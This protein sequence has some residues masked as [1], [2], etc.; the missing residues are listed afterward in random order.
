MMRE[1][2]GPAAKIEA[3]EPERRFELPTD[4][5]T[6]RILYELSREDTIVG[7]VASVIWE[8]MR[9]HIPAWEKEGAPQAFVL[10][11]AMA[12]KIKEREWHA[13]E[14]EMENERILG[15]EET[16]RV[17]EFMESRDQLDR[18]LRKFRER[19]LWEYVKTSEELMTPEEKESSALFK[20]LNV[21]VQK[22][23]EQFGFK[24]EVVLEI[25][26]SQDFNAFVFSVAKE[27]GVDNPDVPLRIYLHAGLV[28]ALH[29]MMRERGNDLAVDHV[30]GILAHEL[31]HLK[32]PA[33]H[34]DADVHSRDKDET[35]RYEYDAD[36]RAI[37]VM[38]RS[39][40]NPTAVIEVFEMMQKRG[41]GGEA[42]LQHYL[43]NT[44]PLDENRVKELRQV[45]ENPSE[46]FFSAQKE[47]TPLSKEAHE[48]VKKMLRKDLLQS[49]EHIKMLAAWDGVL[50]KLEEDPNMN[51]H[52]T[53]IVGRMLRVH[54]DVRTAIAG[55]SE[56][57]E[58]DEGISEAIVLMANF[59]IQE[60][61]K[62]LEGKKGA[63]GFFNEYGWGGDSWSFLL[64]KQAPY[65]MAAIG[66]SIFERE[67]STD[68]RR[69]FDERQRQPEEEQELLKFVYGHAF[70]NTVVEKKYI[71][72]M[73]DLFNPMNHHAVNFWH[74]RIGWR[75]SDMDPMTLM[76]MAR[77]E[78]IK[79]ISFLFTYGAR[80]DVKYQTAKEI[81]EK[82]EF[83]RVF[84]EE[85]EKEEERQKIP[86]ERAEASSTEVSHAF[87]DLKA[88]GQIKAKLAERLSGYKEESKTE[89][90]VWQQSRDYHMDV[91]LQK[92]PARVSLELVFSEEPLPED[93]TPLQKV[94]ARYLRAAWKIFERSLESEKL[95]KELGLTVKDDSEAKRILFEVLYYDFFF[96]TPEKT[97]R[98]SNLSLEE[99]KRHAPAF[100]QYLQA[101]YPVAQWIQGADGTKQGQSLAKYLPTAHRQ[102]EFDLIVNFTV[103]DR[104]GV[105]DFETLGQHLEWIR[106]IKYHPG[107]KG[108]HDGSNHDLPTSWGLSYEHR[109]EGLFK[110]K[111]RLFERMLRMGAVV[112][113]DTDLES[114]AWEVGH[115]MEQAL[116]T[117]ATE[118]GLPPRYFVTGGKKENWMEWLQ[119]DVKDTYQRK[120]EISQLQQIFSE[121][122]MRL[123]ADDIEEMKECKPDMIELERAIQIKDFEE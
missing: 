90:P 99:I 24:R 2:R 76:E 65:E 74:Q 58:R 97:K 84:F 123:F 83:L 13:L 68:L 117:R 118:K 30:M 15:G 105:N 89:V 39:G 63:N 72:N 109:R 82:E 8:E 111:R 20:E 103:A 122:F 102:M 19:K 37:E 121:E 81:N 79:E 10:P 92:F 67:S 4:I 33:Y 47:L 44:H 55:A 93:F 78:L 106:A 110:A 119:H 66:D 59:Y 75:V 11:K 46:P 69:E 116:T 50:K 29:E 70:G 43:T 86:E 42:V 94:L 14:Y 35:Q 36:A 52:D 100:S 87:L 108:V 120:E 96:D 1:R 88:I 61:E 45:Y 3:K 48:E 26:R 22:L 9:L 95:Q 27:G 25:T 16:P 49:L 115:R 57:L 98:I 53:A 51:L 32:Q 7:K 31:A 80:K 91:N 18:S 104:S 64:V 73:Q 6:Q 5:K 62:A 107:L 41:G 23:A 114:S 101:V 71:K 56:T 60:N 12:K 21:G 77:R 28:D 113:A 112:P 85:A 17:K 34:A 38:D 40:F 54:A